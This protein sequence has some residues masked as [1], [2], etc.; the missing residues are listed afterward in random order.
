MR[1]LNV[2]SNEWAM[3][4]YLT[5]LLSGI[6]KYF[7]NISKN[8][9]AEMSMVASVPD[10]RAHETGV[11]EYPDSCVKGLN[12]PEMPLELNHSAA[13]SKYRGFCDGRFE[14]FLRQE[15]YVPSAM[16]LDELP[17]DSRNYRDW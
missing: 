10:A 11:M 7:G 2:A 4:E 17:S 14:E 16:R 15:G 5:K 13:A 6:S 1:Y 8:G 12:V 9:D 3:I